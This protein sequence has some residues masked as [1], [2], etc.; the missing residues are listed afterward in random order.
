[1]SYFYNGKVLVSVGLLLSMSVLSCAPFI[2]TRVFVSMANG[3]TKETQLIANNSYADIETKAKLSFE[4]PV[5]L[6]QSIKITNENE[7]I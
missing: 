6:G 2:E 1:M 3:Q 4:L 5:H 7:L